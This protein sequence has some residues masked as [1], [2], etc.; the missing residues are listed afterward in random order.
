MNQLLKKLDLPI[1]EFVLPSSG[2]KIQ[3]RPY[4]VKEK[5]LL[6]MALEAG[7][8]ASMLQAIKQIINNCVLDKDF[9]PNT[10]ASFD[11]HYLFLQLRAKSVGEVQKLVFNCE[12]VTTVQK[13]NDDGQTEE[14]EV[15]C[16]E[17]ILVDFRITDVKVQKDPNHTNKIIVGPNVGILMKYP[18][19]ELVN[20][21]EQGESGVDSMFQFIIDCID[22]IF[23]DQ[24]V[25]KANDISREEL[26]EFIEGLTEAQFEKIEQFFHTMPTVRHT[27]DTKCKKCGNEQ[28]IVLEG[29]S[30]FFG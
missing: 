27:L 3:Y 17:K 12:N 28:Q 20:K 10:L 29:L 7:D 21:R 24:Q 26:I 16:N 18:S 19:L 6:M 14:I 5:K 15:P 9:D 23:D 11:L 30:S 4:T 25:I 13:E 8:D 2:Q 1:Y 22:S